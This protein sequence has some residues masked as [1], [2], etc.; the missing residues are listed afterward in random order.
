MGQ[1][2]AINEASYLL[3]RILQQ[4]DTFTLASEAQAPDSLPPAEWRLNGTG[5]AKYEK[6]W[7]AA[8]MTLFIK[9]RLDLKC[10]PFLGIDDLFQGGLWVRFGRSSHI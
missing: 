1:N 7:P 4:Y 8:A 5:R 9:V 6:V 3:V 10:A 2:F